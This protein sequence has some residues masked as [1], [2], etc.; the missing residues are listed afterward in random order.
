MADQRV[1]HYQKLQCAVCVLDPATRGEELAVTIW[2]G[3]ALCRSHLDAW[4]ELAPFA[5]DRSE[6]R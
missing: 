6:Q 3:T 2:Q 4:I 5:K 1:R